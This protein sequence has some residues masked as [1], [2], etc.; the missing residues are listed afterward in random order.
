MGSEIWF[1]QLKHLD[2][3]QF[4]VTVTKLLGEKEFRFKWGDVIKKYDLL[5][6]V[7]FE[8]MDNRNHISV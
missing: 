1:N 3:D 6:P 8:S 7:L 4:G 5:F 2:P